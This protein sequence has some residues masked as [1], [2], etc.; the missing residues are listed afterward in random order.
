MALLN[1]LPPAKASLRALLCPILVISFLYNPYLTARVATDGPNVRH[2]FSH[3][4][5]VGASELEKYSPVVAANAYPGLE[6]SFVRAL[7]VVADCRLT[8]FLA[9]PSSGQPQNRR[10]P[11]QGAIWFRPPPTL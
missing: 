5:T 3:R 10:S 2:P 9:V 11:F 1:P 8:F 6:L 7:P 4:A